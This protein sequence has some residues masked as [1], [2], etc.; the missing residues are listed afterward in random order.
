[1]LKE[2]ALIMGIKS[3]RV[4]PLI[5]MFSGCASIFGWDIHAPGVLSNNF[6]QKVSPVPERVALW[7]EPGLLES[8]SKDRGGK[9]ADPQTYHVG[10]ALGPMLI[11]AFQ[12]GFEEFVL[13]E[14][15]PTPEVM[16]QY[17]IQWL[18][19]IR[20][21]EFKNDV[22]WKGQTLRLQTESV[23]LNPDLKERARFESSGSSQ[24]EKVFAKKGGPQVHL[25]AAIENTSEA[26]ILHLQ[27][28]IHTGKLT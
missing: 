26:I 3:L 7:M 18:V 12:N 2:P 4:L 19:S 13:M 8:I 11:E 14:T 24:A 21:L 28:L 5:L 25:N 9:T 10:E 6:F 27:D 15:E 1:M 16:K 23:V 17:G 20:I 22:T